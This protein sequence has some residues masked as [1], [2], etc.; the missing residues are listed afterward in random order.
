M[1]VDDIDVERVIQWGVKRVTNLD[2]VVQ[3]FGR[4]GRAPGVQGAC[5]LFTE[6]DFIGPRAQ[7][8]KELREQNKKGKK[9]SP[10]EHRALL[11]DGLYKF[12]NTPGSV[13]CR[14]KVLLGYYGDS[15]Y[16]SNSHELSTGPCC[17]ICGYNNIVSKLAPSSALAII[18]F[19]PS[20]KPIHHF[21]RATPA[22]KLAISHALLQYRQSLFLRDYSEDIQDLPDS[23][24]FSDK[25]LEKMAMNCRGIRNSRD[26]LFIP[27]FSIDPEFIEK[28]GMY[29]STLDMKAD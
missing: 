28:Y 9:R 1:G 26:L 19:T 23:W 2:T 17:D 21:P 18:L 14:R 20:T 25:Q 8:T 11:E 22:L 27:K 6:K 3:H 5:I 7:N 24:L 16:Y 10:D 12:L 13:K 29:K 4:A 15:Q